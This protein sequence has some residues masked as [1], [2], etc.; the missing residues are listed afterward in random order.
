MKQAIVSIH[1]LANLGNIMNL[2]YLKL[3]IVEMETATFRELLV[4]KRGYKQD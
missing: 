3:L 4:G 2:S 1:L